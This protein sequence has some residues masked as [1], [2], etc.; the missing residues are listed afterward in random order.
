MKC[1]QSDPVFELVSLCPFPTTI[2]I[3]PRAPPDSFDICPYQYILMMMMMIFYILMFLFYCFTVAHLTV[4]LNISYFIYFW[5]SYEFTAITFLTYLRHFS[6]FFV[7]SVKKKTKSFHP[8]L[9][10][11]FQ[12]LTIIPDPLYFQFM[13][14]I[15]FLFF[16][17]YLWFLVF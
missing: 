10:Y 4:C 5:F 17:A 3:T 13:Q 2:T 14:V 1:N 16:Y 8:D 12:V 6:R 11:F 15:L 7:K 9:F